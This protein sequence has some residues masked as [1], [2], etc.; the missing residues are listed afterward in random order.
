MQPY[1][2][3]SLHMFEDLVWS[4]IEGQCF[5]FSQVS[6]IFLSTFLCP[7]QEYCRLRRSMWCDVYCET[8]P[9]LAPRTL[10]TVKLHIICERNTC[11]SHCSA[12]RYQKG[13]MVN[14]GHVK[15]DQTGSLCEAHLFVTISCSVQSDMK[16]PS[17]LLTMLIVVS[18]NHSMDVQA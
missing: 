12:P 13:M 17:S 15:K 11:H 8:Q 1:T 14:L 6:Y 9:G 10:D 5:H 3:T 18:V 7:S 16:E 4:P 2:D